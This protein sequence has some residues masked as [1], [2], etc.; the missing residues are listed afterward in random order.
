VSTYRL[1]RHLRKRDT[2]VGKT[3]RGAVHKPSG[4]SKLHRAILKMSGLWYLEGYP[5]YKRGGHKV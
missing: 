3:K 5:G 2:S 4:Y 1:K